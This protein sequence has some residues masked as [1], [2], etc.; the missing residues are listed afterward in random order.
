MMCGRYITRDQAA[1]ER[2]FNVSSHQFQLH[3]RYNVA[4]STKVPVIRLIEDER[5]LSLMHWGLLPFWAKDPKIGYKTINARAETVATKPAF[6]AAY[7]ARRCLMPANGF[8][9]WKRDVAPKQPY[10]IHRRDH[11]PMAFAGLWETWNGPDQIIESCTI[12]TTKAN[13]LMAELHNRMPV[14]LDPQ[15]FDGWMT[16]NPEEVGQLLAPC[17]AE[18]LD[19]YPISRRVN[20]PRH[21]GPELLEWAVKPAHHWPAN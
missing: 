3:D 13:E 14:L 1:I 10:F 4:P 20:N 9:E 2:Y 5:V 15:D 8:Y 7:Q 17:P 11:N 18:D 6:R 21:E 19:A 12:I 16:G